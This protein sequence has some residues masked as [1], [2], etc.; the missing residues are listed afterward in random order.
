MEPKLEFCYRGTKEQKWVFDKPAQ[1]IRREDGTLEEIVQQLPDGESISIKCDWHGQALL[2]IE[3]KQVKTEYGTK[4]V[5]EH[6]F[7]QPN[8][9]KIKWKDVKKQPKYIHK[10]WDQIKGMVFPSELTKSS[11]QDMKKHAKRYG[12]NFE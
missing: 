11:F 9:E 2:Y 7:V 4:G 6:F 10:Q 3:S 12:I 8:G 5:S 1:E